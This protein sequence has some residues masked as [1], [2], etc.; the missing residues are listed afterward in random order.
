MKWIAK[1]YFWLAER[2]YNELAWA[3]DPASW[4]ISLGK[5]AARRWEVL[6]FIYGRQVLEIGFV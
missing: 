1:A 4:L 3:Y 2:L 5:W 6:P